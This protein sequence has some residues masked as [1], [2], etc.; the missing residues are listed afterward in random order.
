MSLK[1]V[2]LFLTFFSLSCLSAPP[3]KASAE[4]VTD[5]GWENRLMNF[6]TSGELVQYRYIAGELREMRTV[7]E[8]W[9]DSIFFRREG[10]KIL[11]EYSQNGVLVPF[12]PLKSMGTR[13]S[14]LTPNLSWKLRVLFPHY[15]GTGPSGVFFW[16]ICFWSREFYSWYTPGGAESTGLPRDGFP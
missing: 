3:V 4:L 10:T 14:S 12:A 11:G 2:W 16:Q 6:E 5:P 7:N 8:V 15:P 9:E 13:S 1:V